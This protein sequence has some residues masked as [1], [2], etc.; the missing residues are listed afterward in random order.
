MV[1][2]IDKIEKA[3]NDLLDGYTHLEEYT[4]TFKAVTVKKDLR[5]IRKMIQDEVR[6]NGI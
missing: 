1:I 5:E 6:D 3:V 2:R 4:Q